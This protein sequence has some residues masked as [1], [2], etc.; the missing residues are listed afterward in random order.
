MP[1]VWQPNQVTD[2]GAHPKEDPMAFHSMGV[3]YHGPV[4]NSSQ[5]V[6][7]SSSQYRLLHQVGRSQS[8]GLHHGEK[9]VKLPMEEHH[10]Q[11]QYT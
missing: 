2:G 5:T 8:P 4:P 3:G 7:V 10:L 9:C 6:E 1:E 11:V